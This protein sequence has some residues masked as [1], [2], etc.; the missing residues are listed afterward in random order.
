[1]QQNMA[2]NIGNSRSA[3]GLIVAALSGAMTVVA[4]GGDVF[5]LRNVGPRPLAIS[6]VR[7]RWVTSTGFAAAQGLAFS[8][9]KVYGFTAIHD[10]GGTAVQAHHKFQGGIQNTATG[11]RVPLT[12]ISAYMAATGAITGATYTAEDTDEPEIFAVGAGTVLPGV[13]EDW[14]P[15]DG[16]PLVLTADTGLVVNN[17]TLMGATGVG[18]LYVAIEGYRLG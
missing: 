18:S 12:E 11:D 15:F 2:I 9:S 14:E 8:V 13:Y 16:L 10:T 17:H 1:M 4:A 3:E 6:A 7:L 5:A